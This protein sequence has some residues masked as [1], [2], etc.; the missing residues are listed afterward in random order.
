MP[1][2][3]GYLG[4][5]GPTLLLNSYGSKSTKSGSR[6]HFTTNKVARVKLAEPGMIEVTKPRIPP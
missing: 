6:G 3:L 4:V 1:T 2:L 5:M